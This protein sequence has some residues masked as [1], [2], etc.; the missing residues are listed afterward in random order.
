MTD[1]GQVLRYYPLVDA[2]DLTGLL[3]IFDAGIVYHRPG[4]PPI[5]GL[6]DL[7]LFYERTRIIAAGRHVI[8]NVVCDQRAG[9]IAAEGT[10]DGRLRDGSAASVR[11]ADF[12]ALDADG[13]ATRRDTYFFK[14]EV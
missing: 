6:A 9:K 4:Y 11:F 13:R 8:T 2:K 12:W 14:A 5:V 3:S 10:F 7:R 1:P